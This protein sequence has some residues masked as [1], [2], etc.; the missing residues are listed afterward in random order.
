MNNREL[1]ERPFAPEQIKQRK[2]SFGDQ[3]DYI[4][5]AAVIQ[6]LNDCFDAEWMFEIPEHRILDDEVVVL[7]RLTAGGIAKSQ[8]GKSKI[9]RSRSDQSIVSIG[10]DLKAAASDSLKKCATLFGIGLHLYRDSGNGHGHHTHG[11]TNR[12]RPPE[13][14]NS[15]GNGNGGANG[16]DSGR[17]TAKQLSAIFSLGKGK[18]WSNKQI[19]DFTQETFGKNPD[20][21]AKREASAV[22]SHFQGGS[23]ND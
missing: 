3:L 2:G 20:F 8:F 19:R 23:N 13:P 12:A 18:G 9:T 21:L 10:D 5:A 7:G 1:L 4:E 14:S 15:N 22:I 17:L 6:R 16:N 11:S